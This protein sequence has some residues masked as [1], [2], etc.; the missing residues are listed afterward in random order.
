[1]ILLA[2]CS[3]NT[4][5]LKYSIQHSTTALNRQGASKVKPTLFQ[6]LGSK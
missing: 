2:L 3:G 5:M 6:M 1:M 4:Q